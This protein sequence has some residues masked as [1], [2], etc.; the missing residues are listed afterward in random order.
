MDS[1]PVDGPTEACSL[2]SATSIEK[3]VCGRAGASTDEWE[4]GRMEDIGFKVAFG[5]VEN[6]RWR[7]GRKDGHGSTR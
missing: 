7:E 5:E 1:A 6:R 4:E 2:L 3:V